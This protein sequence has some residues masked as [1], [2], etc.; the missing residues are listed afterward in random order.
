[1]RVCLRD[2][3]KMNIG[4]FL[5]VYSEMVELYNKYSE[6]GVMKLEDFIK[7]IAEHDQKVKDIY[8]LIP[9]EC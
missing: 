3:D 4:D 1:M 5:N 7:A 8:E 6:K 9:K 2:V